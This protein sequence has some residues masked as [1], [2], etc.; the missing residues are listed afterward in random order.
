MNAADGKSGAFLVGGKELLDKIGF[1]LVVAIDKADI[2]ARGEGETVIT[3]GGL[4]LVF[5]MDDGDAGV[6]FSISIGNITGV[7]GGTVVD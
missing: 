5:L 3:S 1:D 2:I 6:F 4:A 7:I